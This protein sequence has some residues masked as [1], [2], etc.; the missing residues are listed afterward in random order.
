M[1]LFTGF[2]MYFHSF[3][4]VNNSNATSI[5]YGY[6]DV[7]KYYDTSDKSLLKFNVESL[8]LNSDKSIILKDPHKTTHFIMLM[9][10]LCMGKLDTDNIIQKL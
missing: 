5:E 6:T 9:S 8:N 2:S 3:K 4:I 10:I 1:M 7:I